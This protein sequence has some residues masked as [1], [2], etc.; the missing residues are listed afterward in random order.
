MSTGRLSELSA[1][2]E[3]RYTR[4]EILGYHDVQDI[5][6]DGGV[7][8]VGGWGTRSK[9]HTGVLVGKIT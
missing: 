7:V 8:W 3:I 2:H 4:D 9:Y 5:G 1:E 6:S